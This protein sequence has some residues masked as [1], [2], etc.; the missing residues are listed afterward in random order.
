MLY[1]LWDLVAY[2]AVPFIVV[3]GVMIFVHEAGHFLAARALGVK[4]LVFKLG[5]GKWIWKRTR[6]DTEYGIGIFPIGGYVKMFGDPTE[7]EGGEE[8]TP[9][10][11]ISE[12]EKAQALYFRP[13]RHK[14]FIFVAGPLMNIIFGAIVAPLVFLVGVEQ[15]KLPARVGNVEAGS[16]AA[17]AGMETGDTVLSINGK[18]VNNFYEIIKQEALN[19]NRTVV[20]ELK[21]EGKTLTREL[22][23]REGADKPIG[24]SGIRPPPVHAV[25]REIMPDTAAQKAG[26]KPGDII[27]KINGH[28]TSHR[29]ISLKINP[30]VAGALGALPMEQLRWFHE[31]R[32]L[33]LLVNR[34][35]KEIELEASPRFSE[36][37]GAFLLGI[38]HSPPKETVRYGL[39][40]SIREGFRLC[41]D[42]VVEV[43]TVLY[44]LATRQLSP[45]LMAGPVG[46]G[47]ITSRAAHSGLGMLLKLT[48]LIGIN[49]GLLNLL[50]FPPLD[51]GHVV[52]TLVESAMGR[53]INMKVKEGV[54]WFGF[55]LLISLMLL[56]TVNDFYNF[57]S[58]M[59]DYLKGLAEG[60][61]L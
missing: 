52:V 29:E 31:N 7:V 3:L 44:K 13:A 42:S 40:G 32:S 58:G 25:I 18:K 17:E 39:G 47:A 8:D 35:G 46:I 16:P 24:E 27:K 30:R 12:K 53:E 59:L 21:R 45:R 33:T 61:G 15:V 11:D 2:T 38:R 60:L 37:H 36:E 20:Y 1:K 14:L 9:L 10:E 34:D 6:G 43:Y 41:I 28:D 51:G 22:T 5:F 49:L 55:M 57:G 26:L 50:P 23:L 4:V 56:V 19:P 48:V 54:F